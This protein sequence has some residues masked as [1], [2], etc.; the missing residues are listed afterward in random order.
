MAKT[1]DF[2]KSKKQYLPIILPDADKTKLQLKTPTKGLLTELMTMIP[3]TTGGLPSEED[4]N[5]LY[6]FCATLMSRNKEGKTVT[7]EYLAEL[8]DF[9]DIIAFFEAYT[10]FVVEV[11]GSKN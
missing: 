2:N 10:D 8:L 1:L 6:E 11:S 3:D 7:R 9:E 5:Q 4:L